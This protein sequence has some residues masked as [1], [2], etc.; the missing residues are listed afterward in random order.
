MFIGK[1]QI[2]EILMD[3][4]YVDLTKHAYYPTVPS[5]SAPFKT[6]V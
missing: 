1:W 3:V 6:D 2:T 4:K 5:T